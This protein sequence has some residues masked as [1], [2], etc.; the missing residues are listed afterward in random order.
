M[1]KTFLEATDTFYKIA[2]S[3]TSVFGSGAK[4][5]ISL[6][7]DIVNITVDSNVDSVQLLGNQAD[8]QFLQQ[9]NTLK[10]LQNNVLITQLGVQDDDDGSQLAFADKTVSAKF[11]FDMT[12]GGL[13]FDLGGV[14]V[15]TTPVTISN[16]PISETNNSIPT[17]PEIPTSSLN[18]EIKAPFIYQSNNLQNLDSITALLS[19]SPTPQNGVDY[20]NYE[21][22][23][24]RTR[25]SS[26]ELAVDLTQTTTPTNQ[27]I[28][29]GQLD[30]NSN[31]QTWYK[32]QLTQPGNLQVQDLS[33]QPNL[34]DVA[35][36]P[37]NGGQS[38]LSYSYSLFDSTKQLNSYENVPAGNYFVRIDKT[39]SA[40]TQQ[41]DFN[42]LINTQNSDDFILPALNFDSQNSLIHAELSAQNSQQFY[43]FSLAQ[44][45]EFTLN[46][47]AFANQFEINLF[48]ATATSYEGV[49]YTYFLNTP[50]KHIYSLSAGTYYLNIESLSALTAAT[51][52]D[53]PLISTTPVNFNTTFEN[54][55]PNVL[56]ADLANAKPAI[57]T[58]A[59]GNLELTYT[60]DLSKI[61]GT[62]D[63]SPNATPF[64][65]AQKQA[66]RLALQEYE[67]IAKLKFRE[68]P[69]GS[70]ENAQFTF[71]N[72]S[73]LGDAAGEA[74]TQQ[75]NT[76]D[77]SRVIV[78]IDVSN[79][80]VS[81]GFAVGSNDYATLLHEIGH[82]LG[83]KHPRSYGSGGA[84]SV[85]PFLTTEKDTTQYSIM[86]YNQPTYLL[87]DGYDLNKNSAAVSEKTPL[88][89]DIAAMQ[90]LYGA[91]QNYHSD[92]TIYRWGKD[93]DPYMSIWD[94]GG[95]DTID[96]SNHSQKQVIDLRAGKFSSVGAATLIY[97][98]GKTE[99]YPAKNNV[100]IAFDTIIEN[101]IGSNQDDVIIGNSVA[102]QLTGGLGKDSFVFASKLSDFNVDTITD[103]NAA[104]DMLILER[105]IFNTLNSSNVL[106][107][108]ELFVSA[109]AT[110]AENAAQ[111]IIF[112][113]ASQSLYYDADGAGGENAL[114]F[115]LLPNVTLLNASQI[116]IQG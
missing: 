7:S 103:F 4:E 114:L 2:S 3:N 9:G 39:T 6:A 33:S 115:A 116:F 34:I 12:K 86:S 83:L 111:R 41:P 18:D 50:D 79:I 46:K 32:I 16:P 67:N 98:N 24:W 60:F 44:S 66:A 15:G 68:L 62:D 49:R 97:T 1:A 77:Y 82:G 28:L 57:S 37:D 108:Q 80:D 14:A 74:S 8:Y 81:A 90:K 64:S 42:V 84:D 85:L 102:N 92:D 30:A 45:S 63:A 104:E 93:T 25:A 110:S 95:I 107:P 78:R 29:Q 87:E 54:T 36:F 38:G 19:Y 17:P 59:A 94:T 101:A 109:S 105:A 72:V 75:S 73:S 112:N 70:A 27:V 43:K 89:Y 21:T 23:Q 10:I 69:A 71:T 22:S 40:A 88:L 48:K 51:K 53:I 11:A 61:L 5:Q 100:S 91:N 31:A 56:K 113:T 65:D 58:D 35:I 76:N 96:A 55:A 26:Q 52:L 99:L 106:T 47:T 13:Y 20:S